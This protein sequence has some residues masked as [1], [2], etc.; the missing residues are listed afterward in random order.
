MKPSDKIRILLVEDDPALA[1]IYRIKLEWD[2]HLVRVAGDAEQALEMLANEV[3]DLIFLDIQLPRM[4]GLTFLERLRA[5]SRTKNIAVVIV[6]DSSE[7]ETV[8][9]GIRLGALAYLI[10]SRITPQ[11]LSEGVRSWSRLYELSGGEEERSLV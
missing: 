11:Q 5:S 7:H 10:K 4:D 9:R 2:G 8:V 6:S 3:S 1:E